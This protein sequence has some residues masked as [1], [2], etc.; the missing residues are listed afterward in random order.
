M[1]SS[2]RTR[3]CCAVR[4]CCCRGKLL[5]PVVSCSLFQRPVL[6]PDPLPLPAGRRRMGRGSC[7]SPSPATS[8]ELLSPGLGLDGLLA[9]PDRSRQGRSALS[10]W[11]KTA[12]PGK[13]GPRQP[14]SSALA[15]W[16][17]E[18]SLNLV[19]KHAQRTQ[20]LFLRGN[21]F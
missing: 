17:A 1:S 15:H 18:V 3:L 2:G 13:K 8:P 19:G 16:G 6:Y 12:V 20:G 10:F 21:Y 4:M 9:G 5:L 7:C 11:G 14:Q